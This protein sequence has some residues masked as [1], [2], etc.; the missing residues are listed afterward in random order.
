MRDMSRKQFWDA[1]KRNGIGRP[2]TF[3]GYCNVGTEERPSFVSY[4]NAPTDRWRD[5]LAYLLREQAKRANRAATVA[6]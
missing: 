1:L 5:R 2:E 6:R 4:L 3:M